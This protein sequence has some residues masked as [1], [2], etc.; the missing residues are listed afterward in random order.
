MKRKL[1]VTVMAAIMAL[2]F[3]AVPGFA[4]TGIY[5]GSDV[6]T[7][8]TS[9]PSGVP[10]D[11]DTEKYPYYAFKELTTHC[12]TDPEAYG[13]PV[14]R[15]SGCTEKAPKNVQRLLAGLIILINRRRAE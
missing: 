2:T 14:P 8:G 1:L 4:C 11:F 7:D 12:L 10:V 6:S 3:T 15:V 13:K 5:V 9:D